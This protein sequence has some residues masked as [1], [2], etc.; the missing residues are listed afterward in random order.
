SDH[1][2]RR[3]ELDLGARVYG[4]RV[5]ERD[6]VERTLELDLRHAKL[7]L[8]E[9]AGGNRVGGNRHEVAVEGEVDRLRTDLDLGAF[10]AVFALIVAAVAVGAR[11]ARRHDDVV[12]AILIVAGTRV[13]GGGLELGAIDR[14]RR[15]REIERMSA[16]RLRCE[17]GRGT[18]RSADGERELAVRAE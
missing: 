6:A 4:N 11:T 18:A 2:D 16:D 9:G 12:V 13:R 7:D 14:H 5:V 10:V 8:L 1:D 3:V 17:R 15:L